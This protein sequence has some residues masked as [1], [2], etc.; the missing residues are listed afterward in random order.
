MGVPNELKRISRPPETDSAEA[1]RIGEELRDA[2]LALGYSIEEVAARLRIRRP[3][4]EALEE[5]RIR[6]LPGVAYAVGF[7]RAYAGGLGLDTEDLVRRYRDVTGASVARKP[8]LIFPE[9]V[10]ERGMPA[11][12]VI[13]AGVMVAIGAYVGWY[14]WAGNGS[15]TVDVV[16]PLPPRLEQA[17][18]QGRSQIPGREG[19]VRSE[20]GAVPLAAL[21]P[22][23][24]YAPAGSPPNTSAQAATVPLAPIPTAIAPVQPAPP[25]SAVVAPAIAPP[26]P[27]AAPPFAN[28]PG[29]PDGTRIVLRARASM[30]EGAWVQVRDSR[31]GQVLVNRVLRPGEVWPA[32]VRDNLLLDTGKADGLEILVDGGASPVL[33][34][35]V[36]VRRNIPMEPERLRPTASAAG[37]RTN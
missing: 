5:G 11:G 9:P 37:T 26:P 14:N 8:K 34:G 24:G 18:E 30:P 36:G 33:N 10:P 4:L 21:P 32:P 7:V 17:A 15:R 12:I 35:L 23:G 25:A 31:S 2:R 16:P 6:D 3:H 29:I 22:P 28:I 27:P 13:A 20:A 19:L 1:A